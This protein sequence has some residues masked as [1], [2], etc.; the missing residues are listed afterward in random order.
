M[1]IQNMY[2]AEDG[3][4]LGPYNQKNN[5]RRFGFGDKLFVAASG[6]GG[7]VVGG[8]L[9]WKL[10]DS[11]RAFDWSCLPNCFFSMRPSEA[12]IA[13]PLIFVGL[14]GLPLMI[15]RVSAL[16]AMRYGCTRKNYK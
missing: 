13:V 9:G 7:A 1:F 10:L 15:G 4:S 6:I 8:Y 12:I 5:D 2:R 3:G 16:A 14:V 11:T